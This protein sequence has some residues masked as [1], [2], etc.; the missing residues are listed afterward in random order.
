V[1]HVK[2]LNLSYFPVD[3]TPT[4]HGMIMRACAF[5]LFFLGGIFWLDVDGFRSATAFEGVMERAQEVGPRWREG[6][7]KGNA[8]HTQ[9]QPWNVYL[10]W[11]D[12]GCSGRQVFKKMRTTED[13]QITPSFSPGFCQVIESK[14]RYTL[15]NEGENPLSDA[16]QKER[17]ELQRDWRGIGRDTAF[18]MSYQVVFAGFLYLMPESVTSWTKEQKKATVKK[19]K[20]NVQKPVWDKDKWWVNYLGHPYFG[21]TYYIRARERGFEEGCNTEPPEAAN[22]STIRRNTQWKTFTALSQSENFRIYF[23]IKSET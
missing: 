9:Y 4:A 10:D 2:V 7:Q 16:S 12:P 18:F 5:L 20:D 21:A 3:F 15:L 1:F 17:S 13:P 23:V 11:N 8:A 6:D 19:W 14:E 22:F